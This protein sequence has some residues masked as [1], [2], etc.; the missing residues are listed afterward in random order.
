MPIEINIGDVMFEDYILTIEYNFEVIRHMGNMESHPG[1][2]RDLIN[3]KVIAMRP[4]WNQEI[5]DKYL[6]DK[7]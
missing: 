2:Q 4:E 7:N 1:G 5:A 3:K 6:S